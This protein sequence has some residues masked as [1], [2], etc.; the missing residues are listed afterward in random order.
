[1]K[2]VKYEIVDDRPVPGRAHRK[3][4]FSEMDVGQ[5]ALIETENIEHENAIRVAASQRNK[6]TDKRFIV[7]QVPD[8]ENCVGVWRV[9]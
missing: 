8:K 1:M 9:E 2:E 6:R 3:Y 7:R 4:P 5:C